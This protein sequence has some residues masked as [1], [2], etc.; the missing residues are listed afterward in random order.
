M[1]KAEVLILILISSFTF[2]SAQEV[3]SLTA[4]ICI[5]QES[6]TARA[7]TFRIEYLLGQQTVLNFKTLKGFLYNNGA[8]RPYL[9]KYTGYRVAAYTLE[10]L[11]LGLAIT[12]LA[13]GKSMIAPIGLAGYT[14]IICGMVFS[15]NANG[16]FRIAIHEYNKNICNVK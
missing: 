6:I 14:M 9:N 2:I 7:G 16:K 13:L 10:G 15:F 3:D 8:S 1:K 4:P 12:N 5:H 11:G